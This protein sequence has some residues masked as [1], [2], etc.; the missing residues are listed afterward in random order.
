MVVPTGDVLESIMRQADVPPPWIMLRRE[1][2]V[3]LDKAAELMRNRPDDPEIDELIRE[4]NEQIGA[5]NS[6]APGLSHHR[7]KITRD[8]LL[9]QWEQWQ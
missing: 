6:R 2:R 3:H 8:N 7:K 9:E 4:M 1:I 5:L